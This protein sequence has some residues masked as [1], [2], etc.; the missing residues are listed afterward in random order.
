MTTTEDMKRVC[1][2]PELVHSDGMSFTEIALAL[3]ISYRQAK[4]AYEMGLR[5]LKILRRK[6]DYSKYDLGKIDYDY[7]RGV[8]SDAESC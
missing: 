2:N 4:D 8:R 6:I 5:K 3:N 1:K 7:G